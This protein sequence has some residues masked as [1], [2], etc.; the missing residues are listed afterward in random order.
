M[1]IDRDNEYGEETTGFFSEEEYEKANERSRAEYEAMYKHSAAQF[2]RDARREFSGCFSSPFARAFGSAPSG[3]M[4][5]MTFFQG[6]PEF[7]DF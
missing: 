3:E 2:D 4:A 7:D 5:A 1:N 6:C